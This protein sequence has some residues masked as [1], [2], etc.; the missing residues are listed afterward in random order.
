MRVISDQYDS[1]EPEL[2]WLEDGVNHLAGVMFEVFR[3]FAT[4]LFILVTRTVAAVREHR[5]NQKS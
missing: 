4:A 2:Q 5:A 3:M 1:D